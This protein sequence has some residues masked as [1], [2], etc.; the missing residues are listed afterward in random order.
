M[1]CVNFFFLWKWNCSFLSLLFSLPFLSFFVCINENQQWN[2]CRTSGSVFLDHTEQSNS[3]SLHIFA[4]EPHRH[5][6]FSTVNYRFRFAIQPNSTFRQFI[7]P[8]LPCFDRFNW[9]S[10]RVSL[11][12]CLSN[13]ETFEVI[14]YLSVFSH[15]WRVVLI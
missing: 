6:S 7:S 15:S 2:I 9:F 3:A 1:L 4:R 13:D 8:S 12:M 5:F 14:Y 11:Y 10:C